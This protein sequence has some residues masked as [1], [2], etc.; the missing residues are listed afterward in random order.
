MQRF[1]TS[2]I[3][4]MPLKN[5]RNKIFKNSIKEIQ[6][7]KQWQFIK[8]NAYDVSVIKVLRQILSYFIYRKYKSNT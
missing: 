3:L 7:R 8:V 5:L 4:A 2:K 6:N 1:E